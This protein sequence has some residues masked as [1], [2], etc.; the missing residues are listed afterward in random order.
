MNK[1]DEGASIDDVLETLVRHV[2]ERG[3]RQLAATAAAQAQLIDVQGKLAATQ[4]HVQALTAE[5]AKMQQRVNDLTSAKAS[6]ERQYYGLESAGQEL[7]DALS[8][9]LREREEILKSTRPTSTSS[10]APTPASVAASVSAPKKPLPF[11]EP[12]RDMKR[13]K[14]RRGIPVD[15]DGVPGELV[16][17]SIGGAQVLLAQAV[18]PNQLIRLTVPS[19]EGHVTCKGRIVWAVYEQPSTSLSVYRTGVKF[20]EV[21]T[22]AV[23]RVMHDFGEKPTMGQSRHSSG[24]A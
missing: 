12:A 1:I 10:P 6:V 19:A 18:R 13:V 7:T 17:L 9:M 16:D 14:I 21:D 11:S 22:V 23:D 24:A 2:S 3:H 8:Q 4:Q 20:T 5:L 15:V